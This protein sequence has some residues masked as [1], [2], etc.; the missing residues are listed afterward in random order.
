VRRRLLVPLVCLGLLAAC[1]DDEPSVDPE[2]DEERIEDAILEVDDLP[3]G[4]QEVAVDDPDE[5]NE[6]NEDVLGIDPDERDRAETAA[7]GPVQF[8]DDRSSVRA[9]ILAF[10]EADLPK[11]ILDALGDDEYLDCVEDRTVEQLGDGELTE[12]GEIDSPV[13]GGRAV[14]ITFVVPGGGGD[15]EVVSQQ[16]AVLVDRFGVSLQVTA[17]AGELDEDLVEDLLDTMIERLED[18]D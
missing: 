18:A 14:E 2:A 3:D 16:H 17:V 12:I 13:D 4:F 5:D 6:C 8:E 1:G 10:R 9:E 7:E 11:R 15:L